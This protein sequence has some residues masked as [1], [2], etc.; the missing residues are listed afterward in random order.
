MPHA[1]DF[2]RFRAT[3][4]PVTSDESMVRGGGHMKAETSTTLRA[5]VNRAGS[6]CGF[7]YRLFLPRAPFFLWVVARA[8]SALT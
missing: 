5:F 6:L 3:G 4:K 7:C 1:K 2:T 8:A